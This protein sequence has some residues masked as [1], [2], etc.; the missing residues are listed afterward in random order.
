MREMFA[1]KVAKVAQMLAEKV[2]VFQL[3]NHRISLKTRFV[4]LQSAEKRP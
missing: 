2:T 4:G 1:R 3:L